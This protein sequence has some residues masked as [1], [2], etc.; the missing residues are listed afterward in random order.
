MDSSTIITIATLVILVA[1]SA[2]FSASETAFSAL[3]RIRVKNL[4]ADG[5]KRAGLVLRLADDY[6][7]LL[8]TI[9]VGNNIVN[10]AAT[11]IAT[12]LFVRLMGGSG[13][14]VSTIV[15]TVVVL[16]FGEISPKTLAKE[17]PERFAFFSAPILRVFTVILKPVNYLFAAWK[18]LLSRLFKTSAEQTITEEELLTMVDEAEAEGAIGGDDKELIRSVIEFNDSKVG[19]ILTPRVDV[20]A[21]PL[22]ADKETVTDRFV[23]T[24]YTRLPVYSGSI[25]HI[26]GVIHLRDFFETLGQPHKTLED[27]ITP[28]VFVPT[29][30]KIS[31]LLASLQQAHTHLAVVTDEYGGTVGV[32][33]MEDILEELVG[34]IWDEHDEVVQEVY[35]LRPGV[36]R[37][38]GNAD[39]EEAFAAMGR[40]VPA[41]ADSS[42]INGWVM[43]QTGRVPQPGDCFEYE[44]IAVTIDTVEHNR[45]IGATFALPPPE[46]KAAAE[47]DGSGAPG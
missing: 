41:D 6:S 46:E 24:G 21:V 11:S 43:E 39:I 31:S 28:V 15:M 36:F 47:T 1:F 29:F 33:T 35:Q 27:I 12:V 23:Q 2:Y 22:D 30:T 5:D 7:T 44:G 9:L 38:A 26:V 25:D 18:K 34:E 14:T 13:A 4:A 8:S 42:T 3:N 17:A 20:E 37:V 32:V 19:S 40:P 10:I 45:V 16:V